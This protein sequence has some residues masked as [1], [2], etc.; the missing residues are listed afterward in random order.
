MRKGPVQHAL[1]EEAQAADRHVE[2]AAGFVALEVELEQVSP[3]LLVAQLVR[4][5]I[6]MLRQACDG[7][8]VGFLGFRRVTAQG[9]LL[10]ESLS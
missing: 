9:N 6:I 5:P 7:T 1:V 10:D 2:R 3:Q 4:G 8:H